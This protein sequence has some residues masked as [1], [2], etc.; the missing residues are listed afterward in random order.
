MET[1]ADDV[2]FIWLDDS[3][4]TTRTGRENT[5]A[6]SE[7]VKGNLLTFAE[8]DRCID[9][10]TDED[11]KRIFFLVSNKF[12]RNV[13][14]LIYQYAQIEKIFVYCGNRQFAETWAKPELKIAG[15]FTQK[16]AFLDGLRN[17][18]S[19]C[20]ATEHV[21][22]SLVQPNKKEKSVKKLKDQDAKYYWYQSIMDVLLLIADKCNPRKELVDE[23]RRIYENDAVE[24]RH[25]NDF[26]Q[27][28]NQ[29]NAIYWYT[30]PCFAFRL[31]NQALRTQDMEVIFHFRLF[32]YDLNYRI[33]TLYLQ[34]LHKDEPTDR[35]PF[36][37]GQ[38]MDISEVN[39]LKENRNELISINSFLSA[40]VDRAVA[41][42][43][44]AG[45]PNQDDNPLKS[46]LF[47]IDVFGCDEDT[48]AFAFIKKFSCT[49]PEEEV[50]FTINAIFRIED[51]KEE[52]NIWNVYLRLE[53][54]QNKPQKSIRD[55]MLKNIR[56]DSSP[57]AFGWLLFRSDDLDKAERY[58]N[59]LINVFPNDHS[60]HGHAY[61]L[62]GLIH[63]SRG[64]FDQSI[65][66]FNKALDIY[67]KTDRSNISQLIAVHSSIS[68][69]YIQ[70]HEPEKVEPHRKFIENQ[71][72]NPSLANNPL[73]V[74]IN[75][76]IEGKLQQ[77]KRNY[78]T[79]FTSLNRVYEEKAKSLPTSHPSLASAL[80]DL[81][82]VQGKMGNYKV[83]LGYFQ[84]A[85]TMGIQ[86]LG[87]DHA[88]LV[89][90]YLNVGRM[91]YELEE[92]ELAQD[93]F[94]AAYN[95]VENLPRGDFEHHV[96]VLLACIDQTDEQ[97][98]P[99]RRD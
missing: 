84:R 22:I 21:P 4:E 83:A 62:L 60:E 93:N 63:K 27:Y 77:G 50:L 72:S 97:L 76:R 74:A 51:V 94:K 11:E 79:A 41:E 13:V 87:D 43:F 56:S 54:D 14:P 70:N 16:A 40:T 24:L 90:Y 34:W 39:L 67:S 44:T 17:E 48:A 57:A 35:V 8:P 58:A 7:M 99:R 37:R 6:V 23:C 2:L 81:G 75:A 45:N 1:K 73:L 64:H 47:I 68:L 65:N 10:M 15:I 96:T 30:K 18:M 86:T 80:N 31:L 95:I 53:K 66:C 71:L 85:L 69:A 19:M 42:A 32:I 29:D 55:H 61:N 88:D 91:Q 28:Y 52:N 46:V 92:Y 59:Y 98:N 82:I 5:K 12:G 33:K 38:L 78:E 3:L 89:E 36:F 49:P 20:S 26:E 9:F 25:I